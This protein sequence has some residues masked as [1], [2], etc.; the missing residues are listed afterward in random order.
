MTGAE[1]TAAGKA[2]EV[3]GKNALGEDEKTKEVLLRLAEATPEMTAA[4][5]SM[6]AR[7]AV[8][9]RVKLRL[10]QPFARM[11]GVSKTYFEDTFPLEMAAKIADIPEENVITPPASVAVPALQG[12]SY[13]FE[14]SA[15]KELYLNLLKTAID[16]RQAGV[17][18]PAFAEIIKQ[19]AVDEVKL[20]NIVLSRTDVLA[21]RVK[22]QRP[23][24]LQPFNVL[25]SHL[26]PIAD[27]ATSEPV[28]A[29]QVPTWIDNWQRLG[30]VN[31]TYSE[32]RSDQDAYDWVETRPEYV[33]LAALPDVNITFDKGLVRITDF[34]RQF[35][36]AVTE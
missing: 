20:L 1:I 27:G 34:G 30:L 32:Y 22:N 19:L 2:A 28:E 24:P 14:E 5:R 3:L 12:L 18:H 31:V 23:G 13:T 4:A 16:G 36:R 29:P 35:F 11:L 7:T 33:R 21:A 6:A 9:E 10:Y 17:A 15:L 26:L 25:L 8:K